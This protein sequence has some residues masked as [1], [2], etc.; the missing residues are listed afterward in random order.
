MNQFELDAAPGIPTTPQARNGHIAAVFPTDIEPM[1]LERL[2]SELIPLLAEY[3]AGV[4]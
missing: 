3:Q 4:Q 1:E 2:P